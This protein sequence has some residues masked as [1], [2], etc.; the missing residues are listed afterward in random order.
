MAAC[1]SGHLAFLQQ[2]ATNQS[3]EA[4]CIEHFLFSILVLRGSEKGPSAEEEHVAFVACPGRH[5]A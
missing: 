5:Q 1:A 4:R 2:E 3:A